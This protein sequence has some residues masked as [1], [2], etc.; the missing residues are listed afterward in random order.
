MLAT[1]PY[2][3]TADDHPAR[4]P[5]CYSA[6]KGAQAGSPATGELH[7]LQG[8]DRQKALDPAQRTLGYYYP[9][10]DVTKD[11][12]QRTIAHGNVLASLIYDAD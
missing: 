1:R 8:H 11:A 2:P 10:Q 5:A 7:H 12:G 4:D 3:A 6:G 9:G